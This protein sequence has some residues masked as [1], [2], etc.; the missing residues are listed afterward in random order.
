[1]RLPII[2]D[3]VYWKPIPKKWAQVTLGQF[4]ELQDMPKSKNKLTNLINQVAILTGYEVDVVRSW[5]P[6]QLDYVATRLKFIEEA[7]KEKNITRF[8]HGW[9]W[10]KSD[11]LDATTV[12][13]VTDLLQMNTDEKNVGRKM[14]NALAVIYYRGNKAEY[15][16]DRF[17][18]MKK[19]FLNLDLETALGASAFFLRGLREYLPNVLRQYL[20]KATITDLEKLTQEIEKPYDWSEYVKFTSGTTS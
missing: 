1:M 11:G 20:S 8:Y 3:K 16:A 12:A 2:F 18:Q 7:P 5:R 6:Y 4:I 10:Y 15:N 13:Q 17:T 19:E 9:K 14:L